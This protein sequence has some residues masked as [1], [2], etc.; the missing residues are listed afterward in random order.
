MGLK[1]NTDWNLNENVISYEKVLFGKTFLFSYLPITLSNAF[2][3]SSLL[4]INLE[5]RGLS[6]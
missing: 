3:M 2:A 4:E 5:N 1:V 6:V